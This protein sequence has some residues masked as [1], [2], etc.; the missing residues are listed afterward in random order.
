MRK[1]IKKILGSFTVNLPL[2]HPQKDPRPF[3]MRT[4]G[5]KKTISFWSLLDINSELILIPQNPKQHCGPPIK[6]WA[7]GDEII[8]GI[9]AKVQFT[10]DSMGP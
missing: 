1:D 4:V 3:I 8:N 7:Y 9:L 6:V 5:E 10:V 2:V